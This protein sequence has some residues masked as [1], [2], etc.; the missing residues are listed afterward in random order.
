MDVEKS[1]DL[2]TDDDSTKI[3]TQDRPSKQVHDQNIS[4]N[5]YN[6]NK[7]IKNY[8]KTSMILTPMKTTKVSIKPIKRKYGSLR[9]R[10]GFYFN[11]FLDRAGPNSCLRVPLCRMV[12]MPIVR[13][14]L[15][16]DIAKLEADFFNGYRDDDRVF[17]LSATDS[18]GN[19]QFVNDEV[20][21]SWSPN[22]A[23]LMRCLKLN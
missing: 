21:A 1:I 8:N 10:E 22:S 15:K 7:K 2:S 23:K 11:N 17:Y 16:D 18:N 14:A 6:K 3:S 19:F 13:H 4:S 20:R 9:T 5:L 12:P